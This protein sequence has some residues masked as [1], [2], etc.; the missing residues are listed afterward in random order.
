MPNTYAGKSLTNDHIHPISND[1]KSLTY[2]HIHLERE[3]AATPTATNIDAYNTA[4]L[5]HP[6]PSIGQSSSSPLQQEVICFATTN[7]ISGKPE[8]T[9]VSDALGGA[10][11]TFIVSRRA[12][13]RDDTAYNSHTTHEPM[14]VAA[15]DELAATIH[16]RADATNLRSILEPAFARVTLEHVCDLYDIG[17]R[18]AQRAMYSSKHAEIINV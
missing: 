6:N 12:L 10:L 11:R 13:N 9:S 5:I 2:D 14:C 7:A 16:A 17:L 4:V 15:V 18:H 8:R 3:D 1:D